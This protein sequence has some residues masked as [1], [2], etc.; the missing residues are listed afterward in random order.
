MMSDYTVSIPAHERAE[1][2]AVAH[3]SHNALRA[4]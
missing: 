4:I 3:L 1:L 2:K